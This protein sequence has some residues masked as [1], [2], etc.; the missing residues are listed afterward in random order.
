MDAVEPGGLGGTYAGNPLACAAA[1]ATLEAYA[2]DDVLARAERLGRVMRAR[3]DA[4]ANA[5]PQQIVDV[6][7]LGAMLAVAF[8]DR[9]D[10]HGKS[11]AARVVAAA[12]DEGVV[13]LTAGPKGNVLRVL[14]PLVA[15]D[16]D[17]TRGFDALERACARVLV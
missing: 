2:S 9:P 17:L 6:R 7:G 3:L 4:L 15:S 12:F 10:A 5:Y 8:A 11:L 14:V 16:D 1:L 13:A